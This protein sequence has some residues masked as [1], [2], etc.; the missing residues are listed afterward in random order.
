MST[1]TRFDA[2]PDLRTMVQR[3]ADCARHQGGHYTSDYLARKLARLHD[4]AVGTRHAE[5]ERAA[6]DL[7]APRE[8][9]G[10]TPPAAEPLAA[11]AVG[12]ERESPDV[13]RL[14]AP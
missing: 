3:I 5:S 10:S 9:E 8:D 6:L 1:R 2:D 12:A 11:G 7:K 4:D 13:E 14:R